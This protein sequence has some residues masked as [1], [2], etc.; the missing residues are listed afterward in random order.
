MQW[1]LPIYITS[2]QNASS[3]LVHVACGTDAESSPNSLIYHNLC[4]TRHFHVPKFELTQC[5]QCN[6]CVLFVACRIFCNV[7]ISFSSFAVWCGDK[8]KH[9]FVVV[10]AEQL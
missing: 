4:K 10:Y 3:L 5:R 6:A 8:W 1:S 7:I 2:D 9:T